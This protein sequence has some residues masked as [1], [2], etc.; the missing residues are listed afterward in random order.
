MVVENRTAVIVSDIVVTAREVEYRIPK[1]QPGEVRAFSAAPHGE[2]GV[3]VSYVV[4]G[5]TVKVPQQGYFEGSAYYVVVV[6]LNSDGASITTTIK[7]GKP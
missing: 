6:G 3:G 4:G 1:L 2:S 7:T 5:R